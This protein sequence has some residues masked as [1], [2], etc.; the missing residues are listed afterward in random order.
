MDNNFV[1]PKSY[2]L[3]PDEKNGTL[4]LSYNDFIKVVNHLIE[5]CN[6]KVPPSTFCLSFF[7][8]MNLCKSNFELSLIFVPFIAD[9][10]LHGVSYEYPED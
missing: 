9:L 7:T 8:L 5:S 10:L 3:L 2:D 6:G 4:T 1:F